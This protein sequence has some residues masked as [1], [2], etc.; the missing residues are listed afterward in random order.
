M[1][2]C[3]KKRFWL[4]NVFKILIF[5]VCV[6]LLIDLQTLDLM[7]HCELHQR[8]SSDVLHLFEP[9]KQQWWT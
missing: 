3:C 4:E 2:Q 5:I 7:V 1:L 9:G 8:R 6:L